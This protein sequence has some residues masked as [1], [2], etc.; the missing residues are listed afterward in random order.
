MGL[1]LVLSLLDDRLELGQLCLCHLLPG[2]G[3]LLPVDA[4]VL[5]GGVGG[6]Q[7][8]LL[9]NHELLSHKIRELFSQV[10]RLPR[11]LAEPINVAV[12]GPLNGVAVEGRLRYRV[13]NQLAVDP[14]VHLKHVLGKPGAVSV[15]AHAALPLYVPVSGPPK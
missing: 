11:L 5:V 4:L 12:P 7:P 13:P 9:G 6:H 1:K 2:P 3:Q 15:P 8:V 10:L 14:H